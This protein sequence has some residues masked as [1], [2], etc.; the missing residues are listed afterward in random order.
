MYKLVLST[1]FFNPDQIVNNKY[2]RILKVYT[3]RF[4]IDKG[5][6]KVEFVARANKENKTGEVF[7]LIIDIYK[8]QEDWKRRVYLLI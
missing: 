2:R 7:S 5:I 6:K 8:K 3:I 4:L 1:N